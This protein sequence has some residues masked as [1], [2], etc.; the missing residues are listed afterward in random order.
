M[1]K[2]KPLNTILLL[3]VIILAA[4]C[5]GYEK[6]LKSNDADAKYNAGKQYY[7]EGKWTKAA[8]LFGQVRTRFRGTDKAEEIDILN[9]KCY[10][11]MGDYVMAGHY[12]NEFV[13]TY[14]ASPKAEEADFMGAYCYYLLRPRVELDQSNTYKAIDAFTLFKTRWPGSDRIEDADAYIKECEENLVEK[15]YIS[16]KLY[17]DLEEYKAA[18]VAIQNSLMEYPDTKYR[19]ELLYLK[20]R[21]T[22]LMA[23][24]SVKL[25]QVERFQ[26]TVDE[27][28]SFIDEFPGSNYAREAERMYNNSTE[29]LDKHS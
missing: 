6:L 4:S 11:E 12:F 23:E 21:S 17:Y 14:F 18:I 25:K 22:F 8:T 24:R 9:A 20:L 1:F 10:Y 19:E 2:M 16:A 27:Y 7:E 3:T 28:Y 5:S 13:V 29:F 26:K 15:S